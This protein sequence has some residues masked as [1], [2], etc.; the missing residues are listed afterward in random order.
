[1]PW[2]LLFFFWWPSIYLHQRHFDG[3]TAVSRPD[4]LHSLYVHRSFCIDPYH[5][6]TPDKAVYLGHYYSDKAPGTVALGLPFFFATAWCLEQAGVGVDSKRGWIATSWLTCAAA[7]GVCAAVGGIACFLWLVRYVPPRIAF[8]TTAAVFLGA[9]PLPYATFMYSHAQVVSLLM[10]AM[11]ALDKQGARG[12]IQW[13]QQ[14]MDSAAGF[15]AGW[16]LAS[17]YTA[18]LIVVAIVLW[19]ASVKPS[20]A[21]RFCLGAAPPLLLIPLYSW[22]TLGNPFT[23]PYSYQAT[24]L[25]MH[26]GI[27]AIKWPDLETAY[28]LLFGASRGLFFWSPFLLMAFL[29]FP[30]LLSRSPKLFW[31]MYAGFI[32][33]IT[34]ISGRVWDWPAGPSF[35]PRYLAPSLVF[36]ALPFALA[37]ERFRKTAILLAAYSI[38]ITTLATLTNASF[39]GSVANPLL[40]MTLP[41][42]WKG[43]FN[44]N[45]GML[46]G[47]PPFVSVA[48]YYAVFLAG[49]VCIWRRLPETARVAMAS[50][51][52][53]TTETAK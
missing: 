9:A 7:L 14:T 3:P 19:L 8:L 29:G 34:V 25:S 44:P 16:A 23:L 2:F 40:E 46:L 41:M 37:A 35:G 33:Q 13:A 38:C 50:G 45:L 49:I 39:P 20:R 52:E 6:N 15:A 4:L 48:V 10:I 28:R 47:L 11:W 42:A 36:L 18:G 27:Y 22:V 30:R 5:G 32:M 24:F 12:A 51:K 43:D 17:E 31:V 1:M 21:I 26:E 53:I